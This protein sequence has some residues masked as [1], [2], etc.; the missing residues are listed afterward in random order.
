MNVAQLIEAL[1]E[2]P[3]HYTVLVEIT[4]DCAGDE[5]WSADA[6]ETAVEQKLFGHGTPQVVIR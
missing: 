5:I 2:L 4:V 6:T 3:Q 1:E